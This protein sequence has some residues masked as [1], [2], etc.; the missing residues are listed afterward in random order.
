MKKLFILVAVVCAAFAL[1]AQDVK[2]SM[3]DFGKAQYS[4]YL[5]NMKNASVDV[6]ESTMRDLL[7]NKYNLKAKKENGFNAYLNQPFL[8]FGSQNYDIY[9]KVGEFGKKKNKT[10]QL[11]MIVC[12]G[13]M[14]AVTASN[15][16]DVD[17]AIR[18]FLND[19]APRITQFQNQQEID[20]LKEQ[21]KKLESEKKSLE[22][23]LNK[24]DKQI[25]KLQKSKEETNQKIK[26]TEKKID[27]V[28]QDLKDAERKMR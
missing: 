17:N 16:P 3:I 4:G 19:F 2:S 14:N 18:H 8:P 15:N 11:S 27:K 24:T 28:Q 22:K 6:V 9:F 21:L 13:N 23:D 12:T 7:E 25:E 1:S 5:M 20:A 10:T 26:E